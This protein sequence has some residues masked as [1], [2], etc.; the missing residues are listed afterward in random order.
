MTWNWQHT[1]WPQFIYNTEDFKEHELQF[2]EKAGM[3]NGSIQHIDQADQTLITIDLIS[4]E[5][6]K[7]SEIEGELLNRDSLQSSIRRQFGL[8]TD[9]RRVEPA[10]QGIA[11]MMVH[12]YRNYHTPLDKETLCLWH[13]MITNGRMDLKNIGTYRT[14]EDP[15]QVVSG[16]MGREIIHFEAPPSSR[17]PEEMS[18]FIRWFND[19]ERSGRK[20]GA[21]LVRAAVAHLYFEC[22]HPFEDGNGRVGRGI[23]EKSLSQSLGRPTLIALSHIIVENKKGYYQ[24]LERNNR[25]LEIS[26]WISYFCDTVLKA[27]DH[28]QQTI[29]FIIQKGKFYKQFEGKLNERQLKVVDQIFREGVK[30]FKGGLSAKNY[31]SISGAPSATATRDLTKMVKVGALKKTGELKSTRY[32]L[33]I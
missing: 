13:K 3:L 23:S 32:F 15:M 1:N 9:Y 14:H 11:E 27:Q 4:N 2:F 31:R 5:A 20:E 17:I 25:G 26:D 29:N 12:L 19:T 10:E 8:Q 22:I 6:F 30:G 28:T 21:S 7:T 33:N 18:G 16:P 24:A